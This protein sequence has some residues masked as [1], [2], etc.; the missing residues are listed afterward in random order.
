MSIWRRPEDT[1]LFIKQLRPGVR[2][3]RGYCLTREQTQHAFAIK[4]K[5]LLTTHGNVNTTPYCSYFQ[6]LGFSPR[7]GRP[8]LIAQ[9]T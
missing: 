4:A 9:M 2:T 6:L 3:W 8:N 1:R 7:A 5:L